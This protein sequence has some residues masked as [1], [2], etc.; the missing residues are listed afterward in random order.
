MIIGYIICAFP[1]PLLIRIWYRKLIYLFQ[2]KSQ[3][4]IEMTHVPE[5]RILEN[6]L[7]F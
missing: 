6:K 4:K 2:F 7:Y 5:H 3:E 1:F